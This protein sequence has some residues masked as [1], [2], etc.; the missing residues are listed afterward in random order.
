MVRHEVNRRSAPFFSS[1][2]SAPVKKHMTFF[3]P[4]SN[5]I[6]VTGRGS[7]I[8]TFARATAA[9]YV[10]N[11]TGLV[12]SASSGTAR[13][14]ALGYLSEQV[15]TNLILQSETLG[16]T[17][18]TINS[19]V[20]AN[21]VSAP[22]GNATG[23]NIVEDGTAGVVHGLKQSYT[24]TASTNQ[25]CSFYGKAGTRTWVRVSLDDGGGVNIASQWFDLGNGALGSATNGGAGFSVVANTAR[26][27]SIPGAS[28]WYRC[29]VAILTG[30]GTT[31][32]ITIALATGDSNVTYNGDGAS[33]ATVWG[34]QAENNVAG[35]SA[36]IVTTSAAVT[37]NGESLRYPPRDNFPAFGEVSIFVVASKYLLAASIPGGDTFVFHCGGYGAGN[38]IALI[39]SGQ[40]FWYY[41]YSNN[42]QQIGGTGTAQSGA[43]N[44]D[45]AVKLTMRNNYSEMTAD[46]AYG[47]TD[48]LCTP[49]LSYCNGF[50]TSINIAENSGAASQPMGHVRK[51]MVFDFPLDRMRRARLGK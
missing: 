10:S 29:E 12:A 35:S 39:Y 41:C 2:V 49:P 44:S 7:T 14:E 4:L 17:W 23:D 43:N 37:R 26:L 47:L 6:A 3:A 45:R 30:T 48:T 24:R 50:T 20:T 32:Q 21:A 15:R 27:V 5:G 31:A 25:A 11:S 22:D 38:G 28:G 36:Y 8:P 34:V 33:S 51:M 19:S 42:V 1:F 18:T 9:T 13:F 46:N 16:T 40:N